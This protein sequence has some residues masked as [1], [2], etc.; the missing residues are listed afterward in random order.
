[1][2]QCPAQVGKG[3]SPNVL[4]ILVAIASMMLR[5][6]QRLSSLEVTQ[7]SSEFSRRHTSGAKGAMGNAQRRGVFMSF[8]LGKELRGCVPLLGD[9]AAN[10]VGC[11]YSVEDGEF[12]R[13]IG[14]IV[15]E[16][17]RPQQGLSSLGRRVA[18]VSNHCLTEH[19][20]QFERRTL[21][22]RIL[23][24]QLQRFE[25]TGQMSNGLCIRRTLDGAAGSLL[26]I[27]NGSLG[28]PGLPKMMRHQ[29]G[30]RFDRLREPCHEGIGNAT[31]KLLTLASHHGGVGRILN[32]RMLE[33]VARLRWFA[34]GED[35]LA[36]RKLRKRSLKLGAGD[37]GN[38]S[39]QPIWEFA[40]YGSA[41]LR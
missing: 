35:Q 11:P 26:P 29:L 25:R 17:L 33:D 22:F 31:V 30:L 41:N 15:N 3:G 20:L 8:R 38:G 32:Q 40:T 19:H 24:K 4:T 39:E 2:P 28:K 5:I 16:R 27:F 6:I 23:R 12:L 14:Q 37:G 36:S 7:S 13:G 10:I 34:A 18:A 9:F 1:M 21:A